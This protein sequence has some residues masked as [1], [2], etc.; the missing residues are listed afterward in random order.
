M[1]SHVLPC[2]TMSSHVFPCLTVSSHPCRNVYLAVV[3]C[4]SC[5]CVF[6]L[7]NLS[8]FPR[9]RAVCYFSLQNLSLFPRGTC[10]IRAFCLSCA[11][12]F[13]LSRIYHF[14]LQRARCV[15]LCCCCV[16]LHVLRCVCY[17]MCS[18]C[19]L[20]LCATAVY[21]CMIDHACL[22]LVLSCLVLLRC[23]LLCVSYHSTHHTYNG[24]TRKWWQ[25][26]Q[27]SHPWHVLLP[28]LD[29]SSQLLLVIS[30]TACPCWPWCHPTP[31]W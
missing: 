8:L 4:L 31:W 26:L 13:S 18:C 1:S 15:L 14:S 19:V 10:A 22:L 30:S 5:A 6:S 16:L 20:P 21:Y 3:F 11:C 27:S 23:S 7:Q 9:A 25:V 28:S 24:S 17:C 2:P 29:H 12:L